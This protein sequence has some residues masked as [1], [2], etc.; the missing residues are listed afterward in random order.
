MRIA[1]LI[2]V[3]ATLII[4]QELGQQILSELQRHPYQDVAPIISELNNQAAHQPLP[5][6]VPGVAAPAA[7]AAPAVPGAASTVTP[8]SP[9]PPAIAP[10]TPGK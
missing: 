7:P 2:L 9:H 4:T 6:S 3:G 1:N 8:Y 10:E 5:P